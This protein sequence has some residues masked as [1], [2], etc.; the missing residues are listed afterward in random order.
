[1]ASPNPR[2]PPVMATTLFRKST[3]LS[4]RTTRWVAMA[5]AA[6]TSAALRRFLR[7]MFSR[8]QVA[9]AGVTSPPLRSKGHKLTYISTCTLLHLFSKQSGG[10]RT[11]RSLHRQEKHER[12]HIADE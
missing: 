2:E 3:F 9:E 5:V 11:R 4:S 8:M 6:V 12:R 7:F 1:M 10:R